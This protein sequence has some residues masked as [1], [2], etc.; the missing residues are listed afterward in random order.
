MKAI[1]EYDLSDMDDL[2]NHE[3]AIKASTLS[4][5][6]WDLDQFFR[7]ELKY[8]DKLSDAMADAYDKAREKIREITSDHDVYNLIFNS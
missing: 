3:Y 7:D 5:V 6:I 4:L 2:R 1:L 8:N